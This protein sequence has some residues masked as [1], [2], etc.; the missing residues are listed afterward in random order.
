MR[1]NGRNP[2]SRE[3]YTEALKFNCSEC[4]AR[5]GEKCQT[6]GGNPSKAHMMRRFD[7]ADETDPGPQKT[8]I[9][10]LAERMESATTSYIESASRQEYGVRYEAEN[11][12]TAICICA[13]EAEAREQAKTLSGT[14]VCR[15]VYVMHGWS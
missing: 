15:R 2:D 12:R 10:R 4:G 8:R 14:V 1:N 5:P 13:D 11:G 6:A 7:W 3:A 9:E